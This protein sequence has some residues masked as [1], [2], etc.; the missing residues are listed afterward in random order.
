MYVDHECDDDK[1][2]LGVG[3]L[4]RGGLNQPA[5]TAQIPCFGP[6]ALHCFPVSKL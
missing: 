2:L 3:G 1:Y 6:T 4:N 5:S